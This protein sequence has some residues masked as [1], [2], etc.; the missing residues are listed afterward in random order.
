[1]KHLNIDYIQ[2]DDTTEAVDDPLSEHYNRIINRSK[3]NCDWQSSEKMAEIPLYKLGFVVKHNYLNPHPEGGSA[4]FFHLGR[5][6]KSG[7]AGCTAMEYEN[8]NRVLLL[9]RKG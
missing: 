5:H 2:I 7:T 3:V 8:L 6:G 9:A 4:I 1:M